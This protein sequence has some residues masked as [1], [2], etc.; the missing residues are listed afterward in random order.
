MRGLEGIKVVELTG[1]VAAPACLRILGEMGAT[2]YKIEPFSGDEYRT[3]GP[4]FGMEKTDVDDPAFDLASINKKWLSVN[5][6]D[7]EGRN[8]LEEMLAECDILVTSFRDKAL[9][10]LGLDFEAVH[11]RHPHLVW[12]QM[13]GYGEYGPEKDT[14]GFD[15]T[16]FSARG[17]IYMS[18]PQAGEDFQPVN[19]P[20]AFGDWNASM[21]LTSGLLAALVRKNLTG[22]GDKVTVNLY[23]CACWA[24]QIAL[25]QSQFGEEWPRSRYNMTCPTNN[26]YQSK[27]G[28]W[29]LICFGSY[30]MFFELTMNAIGLEHLVDDERYNNSA[31]INNG[32]G[33]NTEVIKF[34]EEAFKKQD[35]EYWDKVFREK[36]IPYQKL[37][38]LSDVLEDQEAFDN[39]ILRKLDYDAFGERIIPTTPVRLDSVGD[40]IL[41]RSRPIGYDTKE[42]LSDFGYNQ[43]S[44]AAMIGSGSVKAYDGPELSET[45]LR[46]SFGP[47]SKTDE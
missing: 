27:D 19:V 39:D 26:T 43:A 1:Y 14:K 30:D 17:G 28:V 44:V 34:M 11:K 37:N 33:G 38:V 40:P 22:V 21:A 5:L 13:R 15:A 2:V 23:H 29:F 7:P 45:I 25:A 4:A 9:E 46:P 24:M 42:I 8:L 18:F 41:R 3:N 36:E 20:A 16:A 6:K 12:G 10:R 47:R 32:G 35:W 31:T